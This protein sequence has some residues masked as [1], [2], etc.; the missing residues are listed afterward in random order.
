MASVA[1][2]IRVLSEQKEGFRDSENAAHLV[3]PICEELGLQL[4]DARAYNS[5]GVITEQIKEAIETCDV[6]VAEASSSNENV[7]YEIGFADRIDASKV[8]LIYRNDRVLPFDRTHIRSFPLHSGSLQSIDETRSAISAAIADIISVSAVKRLLRGE[9][10]TETIPEYLGRRPAL[11]RRATDALREISTDVEKAAELR[12]RAFAVLFRIGDLDDSSIIS[13]TERI[14]DA[15]VRE[16]VFDIAGSI[17][18]ALPDAV[19]RNALAADR[20][21]PVMRAMA[22][23]ATTHFLRG[24]LNTEWFLSDF[25][26]HTRWEVRKHIAMT[27]FAALPTIDEPAGCTEIVLAVLRDDYDEVRRR[28]EEYLDQ[29]V[30]SGRR[31]SEHE[32]SVVRAIVDNI[33]KQPSGWQQKVKRRSEGIILSSR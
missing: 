32:L 24:T 16:E 4:R 26:G 14:V 7:W 13:Q 10:S 30:A 8:I 5:V 33:P 11:L 28:L 3:R 18:R 29:I 2:M 19:W 15:R 9:H 23:A 20:S 25:L 21:V 27:C 6:V 12:Q 31:I 1:F 17:E 22:R